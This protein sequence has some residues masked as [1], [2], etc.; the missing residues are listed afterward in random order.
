MDSFVVD[1]AGEP[2]G[3]LTGSKRNSSNI[4]IGRM[5]CLEEAPIVPGDRQYVDLPVAEAIRLAEANEMSWQIIREDGEA[6]PLKWAIED[7]RL[8]FVIVGGRIFQV[9]RG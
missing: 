3:K 2:I 9:L 4:T 1:D 7:D 8:S 5:V 6:Q